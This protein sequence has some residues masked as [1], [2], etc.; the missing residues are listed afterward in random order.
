MVFNRHEIAEY[1]PCVGPNF[2]LVPHASTEIAALTVRVR[3]SSARNFGFHCV[4]WADRPSAPPGRERYCS[5]PPRNN[6]RSRK[7]RP[8]HR[9]VAVSW[10]VRMRVTRK[11]EGF[12]QS[13][14]R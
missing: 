9:R 5:S 6:Q 14:E 3:R 10:A 11:D 4:S 12:S 2:R 13:A 7:A 1:R 8:M